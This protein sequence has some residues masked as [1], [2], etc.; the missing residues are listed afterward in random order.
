MTSLP[1]F[2]GTFLEYGEWTLLMVFV[3]HLGPAE[4]ATW[5]LLGIIFDILEAATEGIGEAAAIRVAYH[6]GNGN[7]ELGRAA[8]YKAIFLSTIQ[9][10][11]VTS[12]LFMFGK[13]IATRMTSD[14]TL[15]HLLNDTLTLL[16]IGNIVLSY[17]M[18]C[19]SLIGAQG[20]YRLATLCV[21]VARWLVTTPMAIICVYGFFLDID[22]AMGSVVVG[23]AAATTALAYVLLRSDWALLSSIL[24]EM[25]AM[26][27]GEL[28]NRDDPGTNE[29]DKGIQP[30]EEIVGVSELSAD[31]NEGTKP[32]T[33]RQR[34]S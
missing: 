26:E 9:S 1:L 7:A 11:V 34:S 27:D 25:N 6:L 23:Y 8:S 32:G 2:I 29:Q 4:V 15:Q 28:A 10:L 17:A 16:G 14:P 22:S 19:W 13:N 20:R 3:Q 30:D 5:A 21:L 24:K 18:I 12:C 31:A 33:I